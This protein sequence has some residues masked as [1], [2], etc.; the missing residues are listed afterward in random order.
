MATKPLRGVGGVLNGLL[1]QNL[2]AANEQAAEEQTQA[3]NRKEEKREIE[4]P[5]ELP[6]KVEP[7]IEAERIETLQVEGVTP[8]T[9]QKCESS[10]AMKRELPSKGQK[11]L[12]EVKTR[13][14]RPPK[15]ESPTSSEP[16]QREKVSLR[17]RADLAATYREWS[18]EQR[19]HF[20]DLVDRAL[21]F[22]WESQKARKPEKE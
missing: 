19:C 14:G 13:R 8:G 6:A 18:W 21:E 12:E 2:D 16:V 3:A 7:T 17:L 4:Q 10:R 1:S 9:L 5:V 11:P 20:S 22:Y 15:S